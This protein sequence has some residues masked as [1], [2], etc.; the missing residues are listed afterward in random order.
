[1][2]DQTIIR[3]AERQ[4]PTP[5][6]ALAHHKLAAHGEDRSTEYEAYHLRGRRGGLT[7]RPRAGLEQRPPEA[8]AERRRPW[9]ALQPPSRQLIVVSA[10]LLLLGGCAALHVD[11][12]FVA[13]EGGEVRGGGTVSIPFGAP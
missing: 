7:R 13:D 8:P 3:D 5:I 12:Y 9:R 10:V 6:R 11:P 4:I 1:M 2:T